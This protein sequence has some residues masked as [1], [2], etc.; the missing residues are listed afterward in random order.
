M[1]STALSNLD[2]GA[3]GLW[4]P[5][6]VSIILFVTLLLIPKKRISWVELFIIFCIVGFATWISDAFILRI[7]DLIDLGSPDKPG[8][9]DIISYTFIPTSLACL[10]LCFLDMKNRWKLVI[11]FTFLSFIIELGMEFSG[12]M[13]TKDWIKFTTPLFHL[14]VYGFILPYI[15]KLIRR[16]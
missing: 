13:K 12:Y 15:L 14:F 4:F 1:L 11:I 5:I 10:F 6:I 7:F 16:R 9:G 2:L 8:I 3:K